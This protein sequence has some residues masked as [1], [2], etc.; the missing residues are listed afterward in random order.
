MI[1]PI[2]DPS[3]CKNLILGQCAPNAPKNF[4]HHKKC[5]FQAEGTYQ[6]WLMA[7]R[8]YGAVILRF[9]WVSNTFFRAN[10]FFCF[11]LVSSMFW[12]LDD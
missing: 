6:I 2:S 11:S 9:W 5:F 3:D 7:L 8:Q 1:V 4:P 10:G 12:T